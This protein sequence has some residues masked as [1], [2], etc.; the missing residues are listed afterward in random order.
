MANPEYDAL[1]AQAL[2]EPDTAGCTTWNQ[3]SAALFRSAD[4]LP[5]ADG[6]STVYGHSTTFATT[7]GG[8]VI[9]TSLRLHR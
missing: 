4:A 9:P 5:I 7:F 2:R 8:Q 1:V 3:A 6:R